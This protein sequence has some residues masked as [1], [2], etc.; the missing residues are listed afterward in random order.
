[1]EKS[2]KRIVLLASG[3]GSNVEN[4]NTHF[5]ENTGVSI[6][7]VLTNRKNAGVLDRCLRL[8]IPAIHFNKIAF[9]DTDTVLRFLRS[10]EPDL[11]VLAGFLWK[12]PEDIIAA[13]PNKIINIHPALLP[14]YGGKGMYGHHVHEAVKANNEKE[15]GITIHY[16]NKNYDEGAII[17]QAKTTILKTDT[18]ERIAEKIHGLEFEH[19]PKVIEKL[20]FKN[21]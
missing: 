2:V 5:K 12:I 6:S 11:V 21:G 20:V 17:H 3:S 15:S 9:K 18:V 8:G 16:V 14:K 19:F 1:M 4:I 13:F 10:L 7:C